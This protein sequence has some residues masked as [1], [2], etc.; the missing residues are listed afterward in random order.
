[1]GEHRCV[2][3]LT[4]MNV[5]GQYLNDCEASSGRQLQRLGYE[6]GSHRVSC[7]SLISGKREVTFGPST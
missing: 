6:H 5:V 3:Q 4:S 7:I 1:M 2:G